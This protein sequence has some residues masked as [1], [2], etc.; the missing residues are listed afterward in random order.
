LTTSASVQY[1]T[2][3][4]TAEA[5]ID[6]EAT[7]GTVAFAQGSVSGASQTI[8]VAVIGDITIEPDETFRVT[9]SD[10]SGLTIADGEG[11][12]TIRDDDIVSNISI[13][14]ASVSEGDT[15]TKD[16]AFTVSLD[17]PSNGTVTVNYNTTN[18]NAVAGVDFTPVSGTL[19]FAA[20]E[21]STVINVPIIGDTLVEADETFRVNLFGANANGVVMDGEA[22]GTILNDDVPSNI[23]IADASIS[24]GNSG[25]QDLAFIVSL[26]PPSNGAVR[27]NFST[28]TIGAIAGGDFTATSG[29]L[30]PAAGETSVVINVPIIGDTLVEA[31]ET[32]RVKLF[33]PSATSND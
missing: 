10:P 16:M 15:G 12:G 20:G 32:F 33:S 26:D 28:T 1:S 3:N 31:D 7:S 22:I 2:S 19:T 24:E 8:I 11:V 17:P 13:A 5:G 4:V 23:S 14:D 27:L 6:F 18:I 9:L 25:T 29:A 21:T 30:T